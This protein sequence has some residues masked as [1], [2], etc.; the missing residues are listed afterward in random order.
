METHTIERTNI[1]GNWTVEKRDTDYLIQYIP[2]ELFRSRGFENKLIE[3]KTPSED[4][5]KLKEAFLDQ[6][7]KLAL[8][9]DHI[10]YMKAE[11]EKRFYA[12]NLRTGAQ[13]KNLIYAS[14]LNEFDAQQ[15]LKELIEQNPNHEF[16]LKKIN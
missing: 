6:F 11:G 10:I 1:A 12:L 8:P 7:N 9:K 2:S 3:S 5:D 4:L 16:K 14:M 13:V 15:A